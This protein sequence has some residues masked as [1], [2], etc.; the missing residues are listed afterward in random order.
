[1]VAIV[2]NFCTIDL[3]SSLTQQKRYKM[4]NLKRK[5]FHQIDLIQRRIL[6]AYRQR[7]QPDIVSISGVKI[8]IAPDLP[9]GP[10]EALYGGYYEKSE[11]NIVKE[12]LKPSDR[13]M[14]IGT[15]LGLLSTY[16]AQKIGSDRV[17]TYE[18]N[19][20]LEPYIRQVYDLNQVSPRV[21]FCLLGEQ[22]GEQT[23]YIAKSFWSSS[24]IH[25]RETDTPIQVLVKPF[26]EEIK[27]IDPNVLIVDIEGGEYDLMKYA[28]LHNIEKVI[29]EIHERIIG[30]DKIQFVRSQLKNM[31]FNI[32]DRLSG[33]GELYLEKK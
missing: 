22:A 11:L 23:F 6:W 18:A 30:V 4:Q 16:C 19:S 29:M 26:N 27:K 17:F 2:N 14:E 24:L 13:V 21:N 5:I 15:G 10:L 8:P 1:M 20:A 9:R 7:T 25:R 31:G 12:I 33:R 3:S 32:N 28:N